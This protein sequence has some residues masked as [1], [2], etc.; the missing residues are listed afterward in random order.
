LESAVKSNYSNARFHNLHKA[1]YFATENGIYA[2]SKLDWGRERLLKII[3]T[4]RLRLSLTFEKTIQMFVTIKQPSVEG[5]FKGLLV[6]AL[7]T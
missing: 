6:Q 7:R 3:K 4:E 2:F 1:L 5:C